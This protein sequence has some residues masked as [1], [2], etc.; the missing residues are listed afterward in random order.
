[1][2]RDLFGTED[3]QRLMS[4]V[5]LFFG[6]APAVAPVIG[7]WL[8]ADARMA[9]DLLVP[10]RRG[11]DARRRRLDAPARDASRIAPPAVPSGGA[12]QGLRGGRH[13]RALP[14][15]L[16]RGGLQ[17]QRVL[18]LHRLGAGVPR[19]APASR[20]RSSTR[21]SSCPCIVGI[22]FGSQLSGRAAGR[23]HADADRE[24]RL[25]LHGARPRS[26]TSSTRSLLPPVASV[27]GDPDHDLRHRLRDGDAVGHAHH[28]RPLP[29]APRHGGLAAGLRLGNGER[30]DRGRDLAGGLARH[31]LARRR[32]GGA[33]GRWARE[34]ARSTCARRAARPRSRRPSPMPA[35]CATSTA[36]RAGR[37][38][39][40]RCANCGGGSRPAR[41]RSRAAR[42]RRA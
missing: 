11:R 39:A 20:A 23:Y 31:A 42:S 9:L 12:A 21:G 35:I 2:I 14:A 24:A 32:N 36:P 33:D 25:R 7:G 8:F 30:G 19:R 26:A 28:A 4:M 29:H 15:A 3:A 27:G 1:M 40:S 18:P 37:R 41:P 34:L 38:R 17:L 22:M 13:P 16:A 6:L 5:T 10:H